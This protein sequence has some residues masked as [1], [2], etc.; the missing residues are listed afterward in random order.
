MDVS[1][2]PNYRTY[3]IFVWTLFTVK[4]C[5]VNHHFT[6]GDIRALWISAVKARGCK[7]RQIAKLLVKTTRISPLYAAFWRNS[8]RHAASTMWTLWNCKKCW[9]TPRKVRTK[10]CNNGP[11]LENAYCLQLI[12]AHTKAL[13]FC[14]LN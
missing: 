3:Y 12:V 7:W 4:A 11:E 9:K 2:C 8:G 13:V 6:R 5:D 1:L 10:Q 14:Y